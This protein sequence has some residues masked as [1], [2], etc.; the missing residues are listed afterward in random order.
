MMFRNWRLCWTRSWSK[1]LNRQFAEASIYVRMQDT[2]AHQH[3]VQSKSMATF[4]M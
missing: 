4:R 2:P 1:N 3:Y